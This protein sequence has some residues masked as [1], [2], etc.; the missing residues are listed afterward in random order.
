M[1]IQVAS[2]FERLIFDVCHNDSNKIIKLMKILTKNGEFKLE[3]K[4]LKK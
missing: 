4:Y 1:D 3:E 2:N